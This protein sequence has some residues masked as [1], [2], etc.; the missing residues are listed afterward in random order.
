MKKV[1]IG[2]WFLILLF[3][4]IVVYQNRVFFLA[5]ESLGIDLV[6]AR[7]Q[8]PELPVVLFFAGLFFLGWLLAYLF[9]LGERF[10]NAKQ[11]KTLQQTK[12]AQQRA[13]DDMKKD[14]AALKSEDT[15]EPPSIGAAGNEAAAD[16]AVVLE[17]EAEKDP[18]PVKAETGSTSD[19]S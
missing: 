11:I 9:G 5:K 6:F 19:H 8:S 16:E 13:I 10:G 12:S 2:I 1:K 14:I 17:P 15:P 18:K 7:Y 4:G 3:L